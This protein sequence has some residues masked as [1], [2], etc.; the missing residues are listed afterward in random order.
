MK[1]L[2]GVSFLILP[3]LFLIQPS[4]FAQS[5]RPINVGVGILYGN[6]PETGGVQFNATLPLTQKVD[7]APDVS[8]YFPGDNNTIYDGYWAI[9]LNGHY[10]FASGARYNGYGLAG[11][12]LSTANYER[13]HDH[14]TKLGINIGIGGEYRFNKVSVFGELKYVI[15]R[16]DQLALAVGL[17][18][19]IH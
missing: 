11:L 8:I 13:P 3:L 4:A 15:S 9:N 10:I 6:R 1:K 17:R 7:L 18:F 19:P 12:N 16:L 5:Q 14:A 2:L